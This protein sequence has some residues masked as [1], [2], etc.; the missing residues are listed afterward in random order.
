MEAIG[1]MVQGRD[2]GYTHV[3]DER[4]MTLLIDL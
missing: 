1:G 3:C 2:D 4:H